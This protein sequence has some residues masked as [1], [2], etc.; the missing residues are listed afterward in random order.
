MSSRTFQT[1]D[2]E[3]RDIYVAVHSQIYEEREVHTFSAHELVINHWK[4]NNTAH[5]LA[6]RKSLF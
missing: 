4:V 2:N 1:L 6:S 5:T 3:T